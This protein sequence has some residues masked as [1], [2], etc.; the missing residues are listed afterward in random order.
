MDGATAFHMAFLFLDCYQN[1]SR[2]T[3]FLTKGKRVF[4]LSILFLVRLGK[5]FASGCHSYGQASTYRPRNTYYITV[6]VFMSP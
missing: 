4:H 1:D 2:L 3:V 6:L 5:G